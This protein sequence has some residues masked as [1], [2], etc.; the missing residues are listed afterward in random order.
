[1]IEAVIQGK[2]NFW[3]VESVFIQLIFKWDVVFF[4]CN[5]QVCFSMIL[6]FVAVNMFFRMSGE[7]DDDFFEV[8]SVVYIID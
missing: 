6:Y 3:I 8:K 5:C 7:F 2:F 1:M 4:Q